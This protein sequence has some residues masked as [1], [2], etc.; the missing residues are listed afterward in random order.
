M[1]IKFFSIC[2]FLVT[3]LIIVYVSLYFNVINTVYASSQPTSIE[4]KAYKPNMNVENI[5]INEI[6]EKNK[7]NQEYNIIV[8]EEEIEYHTLYRNNSNLEKGQLN[9]AKEGANGIKQVVT[10]SI[11]DENEEILSSKV[12]KPETSKIVEIGTK[13]KYVPKQIITSSKESLSVNMDLSKPSGLTSEEFEKILSNNSQDK[14]KILADNA[15]IFYYA[16]QQY[17]INGVFLAAVAIHESSWGTSNIALS[18]KNL[19]GYG[20]YDASA[21]ESSYTFSS[22]A[23]GIDL[24]ARVFAKYYLNPKGTV[25]YENQ[26]ADGRYYNGK[27]IE[28]VNKKYATDSKWANKVYSWMEYLYNKL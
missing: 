21:Y 23:E 11:D 10:R 13:E 14:N 6:I 12:I 27:T 9:I 18:K 25:I 15:Q 22:Y 24:L 19:F 17:G 3:I 7:A 2:V 1:R 8:K 28:D 5:N 4:Y 26:I 20:A 16:E